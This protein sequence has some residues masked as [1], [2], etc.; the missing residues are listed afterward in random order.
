VVKFSDEEKLYAVQLVESGK[1]ISVV[2]RQTGISH[3]V[4][5]RTLEQCRRNGRES[6]RQHNP[7]RSAEE[8]YAILQYMGENRLNY[9]ETS[10]QFAIKG[11]DTVRYWDQRYKRYGMAG[12]DKKNRGRPKKWR[13]PDETMTREEQLEAENLYLRAEVAYLKKLNAL[14]AEREKK[15]Q[16][17]KQQLSRN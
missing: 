2:S 11:S 3:S 10:L 14:V 12:L 5:K 13:P 7:E 6:L 15:E 16:E 9:T 1:A 4:I 17:I 8:K